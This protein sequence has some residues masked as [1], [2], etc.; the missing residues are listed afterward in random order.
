MIQERPCTRCV[1]RDI[2]HLCHDEP[3]EPVRVV[4]SNQESAI[5][6]EESAVKQEATR[7]AKGYISLKDQRPDEQKQLLGRGADLL[8]TVPPANVQK[9]SSKPANPRSIS[10]S[11]R[12]GP[13]LKAQPCESISRFFHRNFGS[14]VSDPTSV[15]GYSDW[16]LGGQSQFQDMHSLHPSYMFNAPEVTN[17]YNLLNDFLS[18]TLLS[19][20]DPRGVYSGPSQVNIVATTANGSGKQHSCLQ[21]PK[22]T[23]DL[24][25][26][27]MQPGDEVP[28]GASVIPS[29]EA[30]DTY[31]MTAADPSGSDN[32]EER[33][34]KLLTAK[35]AAG[36]LRPFNYANGYLRLNEYMEQHMQPT[37]RQGILQQLDQFRPEFRRRMKRVSD[38]DL[39]KVE[40]WFERSLMDYD[41][42]FA[43]MA[44]P[45]CCWRRTG[46]IFRGNREMAQL[47]HVPIEDLKDVSS[48]EREDD[49]DDR[50][51][52]STK[53][54]LANNLVVP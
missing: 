17:E 1:K 54:T 21:K 34:E 9:D 30:R 23:S 19:S 5:V 20:D 38:V 44:V 16:S 6:E 53:G 2:G 4:K 51:D 24:S 22:P 10:G 14:Q 43:S 39:V 41:R 35:C 45:A 8:A 31:Y 49:Y 15:L 47:I 7:P 32:P 52:S 12:K 37:S 27:P 40:M 33:M 29:D 3:R 28:D 46:E 42:I 11:K 18:S 36:L 25:P 48:K 26:A 13:G 50:L